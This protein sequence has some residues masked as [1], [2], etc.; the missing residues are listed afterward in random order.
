MKKLTISLLFLLCSCAVE[1]QTQE[2]KKI[3]NTDSP[4]VS[5]PEPPHNEN[6]DDYYFITNCYTEKFPIGNLVYEKVFC[7]KPDL[8][9]WK[10]IPDPAPYEERAQP[11][12]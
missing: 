4:S 5:Q 7:L 8:Q 9:P 1:T 6:D 2:H 11:V 10:N 3:V 12:K